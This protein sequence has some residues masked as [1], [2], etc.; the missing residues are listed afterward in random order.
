MTTLLAAAEE[1]AAHADRLR[2]AAEA[3]V[4]EVEEALRHTEAG[5]DA[6]PY[7]G[8]GVHQTVWDCHQHVKAVLRREVLTASMVKAIGAAPPRAETGREERRLKCAV[9]GCGWEEGTYS[10]HCD[11]RCH[12]DPTFKPLARA[13]SPTTESTDQGVDRE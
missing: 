13:A 8:A 4:R 6:N 7:C 10:L 12:T 5:P 11:C 2:V 3:R 1:K 9:C